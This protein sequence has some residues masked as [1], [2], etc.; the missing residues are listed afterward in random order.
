M[1]NRYSPAQLQQENEIRGKYT[2]LGLR[3]YYSGS[4]TEFMP[5]EFSEWDDHDDSNIDI[6]KSQTNCSDYEIERMTEMYWSEHR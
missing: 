3:Q 5:S 4:R 6:L 2:G 1:G